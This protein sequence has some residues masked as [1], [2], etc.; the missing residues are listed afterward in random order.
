[1]YI[2]GS[3]VEPIVG[4]VKKYIYRFL[5]NWL[6]LSTDSLERRKIEQVTRRLRR[7]RVRYIYGYASCIFLLAEMCRDLGIDDV[8]FRSAFATSEILHDNWRRVIEDVFSCEVFDVYGGNDGAGFAYECKEH[9]GLHCVCEDSIIEIV[10][11]MG[12]PVSHGSEGR[13][14]TTSLFNYAMPFIRYEVGDIS[15][16]SDRPCPCGRNSPLLARIQGRDCDFVEDKEGNKVYNGFFSHIMHGAPWISGFHVL[17]ETRDG[18]KL[19]LRPGNEPPAG[20][21]DSVRRIVEERFQNMIVEVIIT[22]DLPRSPN[23]KFKYVLN[24]IQTPE[25]AK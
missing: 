4:I 21:V 14:L 9:D 1:V 15:S 5:N 13:V 23:G 2:G 18:I 16:F 25:T 19:Y 6:F 3:S 11:E 8:K 17:Q 20:A 22:R 7:S 12:N 10:D 24:K